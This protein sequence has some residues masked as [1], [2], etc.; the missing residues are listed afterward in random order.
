MPRVPLDEAW[1]TESVPVN[2]LVVLMVSRLLKQSPLDV[3]ISNGRV[4]GND[5]AQIPPKEVRVVHQRLHVH[6]VV[7]V[8]V[9]SIPKETSSDAA[10][11]K[12]LNVE[13]ANER[14]CVEAL[15]WQFTQNK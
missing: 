11:N 9:G 1:F 6:V 7:V 8:D 14:S 3:R 5:A 12:V 4:F 15:N 13:V 2:V 10:T